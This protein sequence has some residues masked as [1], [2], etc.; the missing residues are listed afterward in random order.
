MTVP[1]YIGSDVHTTKH[2]WSPFNE[3]MCV[4]A[5]ADT[6]HRS[7]VWSLVFGFGSSCFVAR[8]LVLCSNLELLLIVSNLCSQQRFRQ[9]H[10]A[11]RRNLYI[12]RT[13]FNNRYGFAKSFD[14]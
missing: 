8:C 5:G 13:A 9:Y 7:G 2:E 14:E 4:G 11:P 6:E 10:V 1:T 12:S 3:A